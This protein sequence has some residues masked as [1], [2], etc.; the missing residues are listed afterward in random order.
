MAEP[1]L[2]ECILNEIRLS[3]SI[4]GTGMTSMLGG[5]HEIDCGDNKLGSGGGNSLN[6]LVINSNI[7]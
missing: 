6:N 5:G 3:G 4:R 7:V 2:K 1:E